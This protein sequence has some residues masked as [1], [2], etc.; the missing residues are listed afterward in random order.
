MTLRIRNTTYEMRNVR[1]KSTFRKNATTIL[2][3][4]DTKFCIV[5]HNYSKSLKNFSELL[6]DQAELEE[7]IVQNVTKRKDER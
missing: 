7:N 1:R 4:N 5:V 3:A 6:P 2:V